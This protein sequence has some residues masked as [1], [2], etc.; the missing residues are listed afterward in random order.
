M[1]QRQHRGRHEAE[2]R[3]A[4]TRVI[5][6]GEKGD[7]ERDDAGGDAEYIA[8]P[9][10]ADE[11]IRSAAIWGLSRSEALIGFTSPSLVAMVYSPG[12]TMGEYSPCPSLMRR[13]TLSWIFTG[14]KLAPASNSF[15][16]R[17]A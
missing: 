16:T 3:L 5:E 14:F 2:G 8:T 12:T 11:A 15:T 10:E 9:P 17:G 6:T 1:A 13:A 4:L 7:E